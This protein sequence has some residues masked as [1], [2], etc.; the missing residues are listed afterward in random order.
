MFQKIVLEDY[1][2]CK[3]QVV[4]VYSV[5]EVEERCCVLDLYLSKLPLDASACDV[6]YLTPLASIPKD[7]IKPWFSPISVGRNTL[8]TMVHGICSNGNI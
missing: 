5:P 1:V 6:F 3:L 7:A 8:S 2:S 4:L